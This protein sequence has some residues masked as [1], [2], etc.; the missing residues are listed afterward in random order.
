[1]DVLKNGQFIKSDMGHSNP[2]DHCTVS[3]ENEEVFWE[4]LQRE[5]HFIYPFY[6]NSGVKIKFAATSRYPRANVMCA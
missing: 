5:V 1:M 2:N 6:G 4:K 3:P